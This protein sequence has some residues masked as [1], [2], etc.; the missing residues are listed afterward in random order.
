VDVVSVTIADPPLPT[1][2]AKGTNPINCITNGSIDFTFT[3]VP[4]GTYTISYDG[5]NFAD[6]AVSG[7]KAVI[8]APVGAYANLKITLDGCTSVNVASITLS[9]PATP[10]LIAAGIN[11]PDCTK[12]GTI[13]FTFTN[14]PV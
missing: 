2:V 12:D 8:T 1:L 4:D 3:N 7:N 9:A 10:T 14:V 11:P 13:N 5:G 6:V